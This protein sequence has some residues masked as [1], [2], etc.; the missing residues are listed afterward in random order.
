[1]DWN[2]RDSLGYQGASCARIYLEENKYMKKEQGFLSYSE[3]NR[4]DFYLSL[5][6]F[7]TP[8]ISHY[9]QCMYIFYNIRDVR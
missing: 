7:S 8:H 5:S 9:W 6:G 4:F 2:Q 1:M 3:L